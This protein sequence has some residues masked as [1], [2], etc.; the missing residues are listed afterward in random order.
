MMIAA[1]VSAVLVPIGLGIHGQTSGTPGVSHKHA[2]AMTSKPH[3][4]CI[5]FLCL[6]LAVVLAACG[7]DEPDAHDAPR[8]G[9]ACISERI[10]G[11][12]DG[13]GHTNVVW[14]LSGEEPAKDITCLPGDS[15]KSVDY[16]S[17]PMHSDSCHVDGEHGTVIT[18]WDLRKSA[19]EGER[20]VRCVLHVYS[21]PWWG[22]L[23][24]F[25]FAFAFF[26]TMV[27]IA[28]SLVM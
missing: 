9:D 16:R 7:G 23:L 22:Y 12:E 18:A 21:L 25:V 6:G 4:H 24:T 10:A 26:S 28:F 5:L 8:N 13:V 1:S 27:F 3:A 17:G 11:D 14:D 2:Q 19:D 15:G 20:M